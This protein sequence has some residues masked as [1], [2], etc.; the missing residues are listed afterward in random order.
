MVF[1]QGAARRDSAA[2]ACLLLVE[3]KA[4]ELF[5]SDEVLSEIR[6]VLNRPKVRHKLPAL[7]DHRVEQF[8]AAL[9]NMA[10][11]IHEVPRAVAY[12]R[13]PKDEPYLNLAIAARAGFLVSRDG[14]F[15]DLA[16]PSNADG[17]VLRSRAPGLQILDPVSFLL[18]VRRL[19]KTSP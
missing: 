14:D 17:E 13:D 7:N 4:I 12:E 10:E 16:N 2:G 1:L 19:S 15:L 6:D 18:E 9:E 5:L 8:L 11:I 3:R